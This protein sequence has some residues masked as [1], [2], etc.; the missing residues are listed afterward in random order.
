MPVDFSNCGGVGEEDSSPRDECF[1]CP[2]GLHDGKE[3]VTVNGVISFGK[4]TKCD[5]RTLV[6]VVEKV[7]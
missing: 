5:G 7:G 2:H 6:V 4:V 1:S 3:E